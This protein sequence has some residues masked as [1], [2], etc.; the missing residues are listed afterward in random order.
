MRIPL[1]A[2][3]HHPLFLS[4][5]L[6]AAVVRC[7]EALPEIKGIAT[8]AQEVERGDLFVALAG[9]RTDGAAFIEQALS[10]GAAGILAASNAAN[11]FIIVVFF[12]SLSLSYIVFMVKS[13]S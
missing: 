2:A 8:H 4:R 5:A 3:F 12:I 9:E 10:R 11:V 1:F 7:G 13:V 6:G